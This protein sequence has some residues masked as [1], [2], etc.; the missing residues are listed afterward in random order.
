MPIDATTA[1]TVAKAHG[2]NLSDAA[3]LARLADTPE[4]A[5]E[6]AKQFAPDVD[7]ADLLPPR[8]GLSTRR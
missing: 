2:L 4:Q 8:D 6:M 5:T 7:V 3:A 1:T